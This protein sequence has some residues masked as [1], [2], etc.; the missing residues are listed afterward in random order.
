MRQKGKVRSWDDPKGFGFIEPIG[1]G[2]DVFLH[3]SA[4]PNR[5]RRPEIGQF[6]TYTLTADGQGRP[7]AMSATLPGDKLR[8][9]KKAV[10]KKRGGAIAALIIASTFLFI[11]AL[12]SLSG[13]TPVFFLW[14]Y[15]MA[16]LVTFFVYAFDKAAAKRDA[17]RT[18]EGSLH[19]LSVMGGWPGALIAQQVLRHKSKKAS[20]RAVFRV[21]VIFNLLGVAWLNWV[22][23][24]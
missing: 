10:P 1:G 22:L 24:S 15:L 7:R 11:V 20:F 18:S 12:S 19:L 14:T 3:I 9:D 8:S 2:K 5:A 4:F 16:S 6:V 23:L 21:T 13:G 17:W